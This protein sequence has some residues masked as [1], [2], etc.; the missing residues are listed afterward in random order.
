MTGGGLPSREATS[1][2]LHG[3][4]HD[5]Y[6]GYSVVADI[7]NRLAVLV[8]GD[9]FAPGCAGA[10]SVDF[11]HCQVHHQAVGHGTEPVFLMGLEEDVLLQRSS[12]DLSNDLV[13]QPGDDTVGI[14]IGQHQDEVSGPGLDERLERG[15]RG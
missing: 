6:R 5:V 11:Q 2:E 13:G 3:S 15:D 12:T 4:C 1:A 8:V 7:A 9:V 14:G 10:F